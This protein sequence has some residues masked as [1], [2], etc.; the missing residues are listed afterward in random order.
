MFKKFF[1]FAG[2][3][4]DFLDV[5][6]VDDDDERFVG[7]QRLDVVEKGELRLHR[8]PT[9]M[10]LIKRGVGLVEMLNRDIR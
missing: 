4:L 6:F 1:T 10:S 9:L 3:V 7:E 2:E 8:I 5:D